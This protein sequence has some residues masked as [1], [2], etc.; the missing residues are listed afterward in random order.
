MSQGTSAGGQ[1]H[2]VVRREHVAPDVNAAGVVT[3]IF[4]KL[5]TLWTGLWSS[6]TDLQ[7]RQSP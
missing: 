3:V 7:Q 5:P 4:E 6:A 1:N 2:V